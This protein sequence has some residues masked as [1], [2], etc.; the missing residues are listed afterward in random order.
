V[1][2]PRRLFIQLGRLRGD[3][4]ARQLLVEHRSRV[5]FMDL[6]AAGY[7]VDD[8]ADLSRMRRYESQLPEG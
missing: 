8:S 6:P 5:R 1:I 4:G 7:D 2:F 3:L